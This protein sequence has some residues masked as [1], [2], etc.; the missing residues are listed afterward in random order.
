MTEVELHGQV[1]QD[2]DEIVR[3]RDVSISSPE[4]K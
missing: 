2:R 3:L 1:E 4:L